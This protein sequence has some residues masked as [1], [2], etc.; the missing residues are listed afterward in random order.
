MGRIEISR[1]H[2]HG[3][4]PDLR[5][6]RLMPENAEIPRASSYSASL[7]RVSRAAVPHSG[8]FLDA[9]RL[10]FVSDIL[11]PHDD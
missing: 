1:T 11:L 3:S 8:S 2:A 7:D 5:S 4:A 6:F 9:S 10:R